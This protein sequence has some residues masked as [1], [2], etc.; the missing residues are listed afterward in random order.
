VTATPE[1]ILD[2]P[3]A[4]GLIIRGS[5]W[6]LASSGAGIALGL[7]TASL[8]LHH[9]GVAE[10]GRYVTVMSLVSITSTVADLGLGATSSREI[11]LRRGAERR[12]LIANV[13]GL[14]LLI[15]PPALLVAVLFGLV[16]GYPARMVIGTVLAGTGALLVSIAYSFM[17]RLT[18]EL[19]SIGWAIWDFTRQAVTLV[20]V[21]A[22]VAL[23]ARLTP[24]FAVLILT[25]LVAIA[26]VPLLAG[27]DAYMLPRFDREQQRRLVRTALPMA[28]AL[29]LGEVYF[30]IVIV[31]MSLISNPI[32]TGYYGG[33]LRAM[34]SLIDIPTLIVG[35]AMPLLATAARN[36]Q[37]RMRYAIEG[38]SKGAVIAGVLLVLV[39]IRAAEPVMVLIG[40]HR[41]KPAGD[42]LRIQVGALV[43]ISLYQIWSSSLLAL[44]RQRELIFTNGLA[45]LGVTVFALALVP[46]FG[47]KG[48]AVAGVLGDAFLAALI[49][50]RLHRVTGR[51]MAGAGFLARVA[52]AAAAAVVPLLLTGLPDLVAAALSALVFIVVGELVGMVPAELH[53]ALHPGR[54]LGRR[55]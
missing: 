7:V 50:W 14:R 43:F 52:V 38:L 1:D 30:R 3:K 33:S 15:M 19:R 41:F 28:I 8:L 18:V 4:G 51:V 45:L 23:D 5:V 26:V 20:G 24:F 13:L 16:A 42:V 47:A 2:T 35:I 21:A 27:W 55:Q 46:E 10:S 54:L 40:G 39:T 34:E 48:G 22:L 17:T 9:L 31:L 11:A 37:P 32:Q 36:D 6:R 12:A 29:V 25:G 49:Y 44:D 53:G